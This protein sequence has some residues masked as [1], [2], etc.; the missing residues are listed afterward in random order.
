MG[1]SNKTQGRHTERR[2]GHGAC[3]KETEERVTGYSESHLLLAS[4]KMLN[5][6]SLS[7]SLSYVIRLF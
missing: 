4:V 7:L 3:F 5:V 2:K 6:L 1:A